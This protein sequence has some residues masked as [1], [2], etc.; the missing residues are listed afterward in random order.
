MQDFENVFFKV[1][2]RAGTSHLKEIGASHL[3]KGTGSKSPQTAFAVL[4]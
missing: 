4:Y 3:R 1:W 2:S